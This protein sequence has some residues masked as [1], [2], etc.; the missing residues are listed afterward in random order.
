LAVCR[1]KVS[2]GVDFSDE[3][4]RGVIVLGIPYPS[5]MDLKIQTKILHNDNLN[6]D[7]KNCLSGSSWY[8]LIAYRAINQAIGRC[9]RHID[10]YGAILLVDDRYLIQ[11]NK[12]MISKWIRNNLKYYKDINSCLNRLSTFFSKEK[13]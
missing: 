7:N 13:R 5:I 6:K 8:N 12:E 2:E 9:I 11:S 10:D 4:A 1:G 3:Q